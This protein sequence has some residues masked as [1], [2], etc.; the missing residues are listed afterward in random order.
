VLK[1]YKFQIRPIHPPLGEFHQGV[2]STVADGACGL[3]GAA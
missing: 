3:A 2:G 1:V